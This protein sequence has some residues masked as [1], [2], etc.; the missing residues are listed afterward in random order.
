MVKAVKSSLR[1]PTSPLT[2]ARWHTFWLLQ[3]YR[4]LQLAS[5][6]S[7]RTSPSGEPQSFFP[8]YRLCVMPVEDVQ[9]MVSVKYKALQN[10]NIPTFRLACCS[11]SFTW[12]FSFA[13]I[14]YSGSYFNHHLF[15][16]YACSWSNVG[17]SLIGVL[18]APACQALYQ[19]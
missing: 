12:H 4:V 17:V 3:Y 15:A 6:S 9:R 16:I 10:R 8:A 7:A 13:F 2:T 14:F 5:H 18:E 19:Q 1:V 11:I